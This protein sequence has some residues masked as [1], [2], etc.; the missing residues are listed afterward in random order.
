MQRGG[1]TVTVL[2]RPGFALRP[3]SCTAIMQAL[4]PLKPRHNSSVREVAKQMWHAAAV[5]NAAAADHPEL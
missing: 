2:H 5:S 3:A 4:I 1:E